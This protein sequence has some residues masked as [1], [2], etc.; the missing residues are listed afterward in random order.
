M[1]KIAI[2]DDNV[3]LTTEVE[4]LLNTV[5]LHYHIKI[6]TD[7]FLTGNRCIITFVLALIMT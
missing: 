4:P 1:L 7:I 5:S 6:D 3:P 2:C